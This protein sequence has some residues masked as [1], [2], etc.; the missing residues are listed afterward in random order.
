M[1]RQKILFVEM[2]PGIFF[3]RRTLAPFSIDF[4]AS[5]ISFLRPR[6]DKPS[7]LLITL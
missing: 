3:G 7:S 1:I 5:N 4:E 2:L 6:K